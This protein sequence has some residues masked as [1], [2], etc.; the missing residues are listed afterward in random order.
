MKHILFLL[1]LA[2]FL[3]VI[4]LAQ[5]NYKPGYV[6]DMKGD[7]LRGFIDYREWEDNPEAIIFKKAIADRTSSKYTPQNIASFNLDGIDA[8]KSYYGQISTDFI[9]ANRIAEGKDT[10]FVVKAVFL[11]IVQTGKYVNFYSYTDAIKTRLYIEETDSHQITELHYRLY[12]SASS[13][14]TV[15]ENTFMRQLFTL[16]A[17]YDEL[18][19]RIKSD[20]E[21]LEYAKEDVLVIINKINQTTGNKRASIRSSKPGNAFV[22]GAGLNI[23]A[24]KA[25]GRYQLNGGTDYTSVL[26]K[27]SISF[28]EFVNPITRKLVFSGEVSLQGLNYRS[29]FDNRVVPYYNITYKFNDLVA[30]FTPQVIY[31]FYNSDSFKFYGDLGL[32]ISYNFYSNKQYTSPQGSVVIDSSPFFFITANAQFIAKAGFLFNNKIGVNV[33][34]ISGTEISNDSYYRLSTSSV[35]VTLEYYSYQKEQMKN[36]LICTVLITS[37]LHLNL[38]AQGSFKPGFIILDKSDTLKGL[39]RYIKKSNEESVLFRPTASAQVQKLKA[40]NIKAFKINGSK[41]L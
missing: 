27:V 3:P 7:T 31:N 34:Y 25:E 4:C 41:T 2:G 40:S 35:Q 18:D 17:K 15:A 1:G 37:F 32:L 21:H 5:S 38:L 33:G 24:F 10:T 9:D 12:N 30:G 29:A 28:D 19:D 14:H 6:V 16:A 8:Y 13:S 26:P 22:I 11:Q 39:L 20:I 23:T 36:L